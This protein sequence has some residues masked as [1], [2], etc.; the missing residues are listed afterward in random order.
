MGASLAYPL[1]ELRQRPAET[2]DLPRPTS[3][4]VAAK[5]SHPQNDSL[6]THEKPTV[7]LPRFL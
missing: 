3:A 4:I 6:K 7:H 2:N 1:T 5:V